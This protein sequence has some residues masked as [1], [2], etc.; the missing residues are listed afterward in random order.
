MSSFLGAAIFVTACR[1]GIN[2]FTDWTHEEFL[3]IM[4]PNRGKQRPS[5]LPDNGSHQVF[6]R[7]LQDHELPKSVDWRGSGIDSPVKDQAMCGSC[8][9]C[10][11]ALHTPNVHHNSAVSLVK[12]LFLRS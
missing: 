6:Q 12:T 2:Q 5:M 3:A 1:L 4:L 9:V 11:S 10:Y 8:W 7:K